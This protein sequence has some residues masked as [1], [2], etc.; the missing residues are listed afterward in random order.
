MDIPSTVLRT[1][2]LEDHPKRSGMALQDLPIQRPAQIGYSCRVQWLR[3]CG[4]ATAVHFA[5]TESN[6][7]IKSIDLLSCYQLLEDPQENHSLWERLVL[8]A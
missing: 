6:K 5:R 4:P 2:G 7:L 1:L 8:F 3:A